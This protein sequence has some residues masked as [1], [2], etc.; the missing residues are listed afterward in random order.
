M[1]EKAGQDGD[2]Y[3]D[4]KY[5]RLAGR[6]AWQGV[7]VGL[8]ESLKI[9]KESELK[10]YQKI[11]EQNPYF[12]EIFNNAIDTL[13]RTLGTDGNL[14]VVIVEQGIKKAR[15]LINWSD[16]L[17]R[18]Y[19]IKDDVFKVPKKLSALIEEQYNDPILYEE[20]FFKSKRDEIRIQKKVDRMIKVFDKEND[21]SVKKSDDLQDFRGFK[22]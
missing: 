11:L 10:D 9:P 20:G 12:L 18:G 1:A 19:N 22:T 16:K 15:E 7:I 13:C 2:Y 14:N 21:R 17:S 4:K 5:V 8:S 3:T 6:T